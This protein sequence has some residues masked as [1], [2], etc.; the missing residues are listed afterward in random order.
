MPEIALGLHLHSGWLDQQAQQKLVD[1]LR[2]IVDKAPLF[3]P[4]MPRS[5]RPFSVKMT[6][7]GSLGW[8]SDAERGY[9]YQAAHPETG[10][11]WPAIPLIAIQAW[12]DLGGYHKPPEACLVNFYE[13]SARMGLHQDRD[14][15][16][17]NAPVV[18][19]SL[20]DSCMFRVGGNA[21]SNAT[22]SF[23]LTSG[24]ALVIGGP[25][26]LAFHGVDRL[27]PGTSTLLPKGGRINL[28]LR[29]VNL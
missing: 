7:C 25:S 24:D 17:L 16:N 29:R 5:G 28:T 1:E 6:N 13:P 14:E 10:E 18:S 8:V 11:D 15:L 12:T 21:R 26:R 22:R 20:G 27:L 19:L 23:K 9:R 2:L 4:R 3:R